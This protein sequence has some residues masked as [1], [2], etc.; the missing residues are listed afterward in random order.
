M[1][2]NIIKIICNLSITSNLNNIIFLQQILNFKRT[3]EYLLLNFLSLIKG[4]YL[5]ISIFDVIKQS[6]HIYFTNTI[7]A[8]NLHVFYLLILIKYYN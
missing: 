8:Y 7:Y 2:K 1:H 4:P 5:G 6:L 3:F